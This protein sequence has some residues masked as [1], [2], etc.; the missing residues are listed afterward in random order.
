MS[1]QPISKAPELDRVFVAGWQP[2]RG[3]CAGYWWWHEDA[4][5]DGKA[6]EHPDATLWHPIVL[7]EFPS[8][9]E[10]Q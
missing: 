8:P 1:W 7:A 6:I 4:V 3:N 9:P 2:R 10:A 5:A